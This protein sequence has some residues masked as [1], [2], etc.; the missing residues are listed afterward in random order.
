M[1][2]NRQSRHWLQRQNRDP[3]VKRARQQGYRSRAVYK[4]IQITEKYRLIQSHSLIADLG[5]APGGWSQYLSRLVAGPGQIFSVDL[6]PMPSVSNVCFIQGD[7]T[8]PVVVDQICEKIQNRKLDIVLS[9]MA[10]NI[11]GIQAA[12]QAR[13]EALHS[14][15]LRFCDRALGKGGS[16]LI[17][18]FAGETMQSTQ[19][20]LAKCFACVQTIKPD[21]SRAHSKEIYLLARHFGGL[22]THADRKISADIV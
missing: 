7:F 10:P 11:S 4:L 20:R 2:K 17:K 9:D 22:T 14:A 3:Y 15:V 6:L 8:C 16:L 13:A 18:V 5:S 21:A 1:S 19:R 12:D